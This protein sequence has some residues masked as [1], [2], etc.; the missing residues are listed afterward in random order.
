VHVD[1]PAVAVDR[2]RAPPSSVERVEPAG[3]IGTEGRG[4]RRDILVASRGGEQFVEVS[5]G[6]V[7]GAITASPYLLRVPPSSTSTTKYHGTPRSAD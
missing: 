5:L 1:E 7:L 3:E 4:R 2:G 6:L